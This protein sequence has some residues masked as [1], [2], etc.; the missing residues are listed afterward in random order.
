MIGSSKETAKAA[1][2]GIWYKLYPSVGSTGL[3]KRVLCKMVKQWG[4]Y[5]KYFI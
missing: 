2:I 3:G 5:L 1:A 4:N